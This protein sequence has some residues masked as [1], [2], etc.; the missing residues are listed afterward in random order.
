MELSN[1]ASV[2]LYLTVFLAATCF[3]YLGQKKNNKIFYLLAILLPTLLIGFRYSAGT[4]T[5]TYREFYKEIGHEDLSFTLARVTTGS[6]EPFIVGVSYLGNLL[7][8]DASFLLLVFAGITTAFLLGTA[9]LFSRERGWLYFGALLLILLPESLNMMRQVAAI[10][11]QAYA[12]MSIFVAQKKNERVHWLTV[13][14]LIIFSI[15]LHYS[16]AILLP[17]FLV[18][19][20]TKC[21][22]W[23]SLVVVLLGIAAACLFAYPLIINTAFSLGI[24]SEK[25]VATFLDAEGSL[26]NIKFIGAIALA[27]I[28]LASKHRRDSI[29]D[30]QMSTLMIAGTIYSAIGFYSA[31]LGRLAMLFWVFIIMLGVDLVCQLSQ[32]ESRRVAI[33]LA[34]AISYFVIYYC[35][36]GLNAI[37][38]YD[39]AL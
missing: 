12:L 33:S 6:M 34:V 28:F 19:A 23:R 16:S 5:L 13:I 25:H 17:V 35:V 38:P 2:V 39:F 8:L 1:L 31:Y 20:A 14:A 27:M 21:K 32:K 3:A 37:V 26:I 18:P 10:S 29:E 11:V 7:H 30:K 36:L 9:R 15:S 4:D 22:C 24:F